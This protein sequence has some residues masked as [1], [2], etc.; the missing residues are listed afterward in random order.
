MR[1]G[2]AAKEVIIT[3]ATALYALFLVRWMFPGAYARV[4]N[5]L[6]NLPAWWQSIRDEWAWVQK[7]RVIYDGPS[8]EGIE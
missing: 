2:E 5:W 8:A 7:W 1:I 4:W 6:C 3:G